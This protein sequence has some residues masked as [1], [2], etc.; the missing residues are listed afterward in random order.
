MHRRTNLS[1]PDLVSLGTGK[2]EFSIGY[3][4]LASAKADRVNSFFKFATISVGLL[5]PFNMNVFVIRGM[6]TCS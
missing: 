3:I 2:Y 5:S 1:I 4:D 6:G